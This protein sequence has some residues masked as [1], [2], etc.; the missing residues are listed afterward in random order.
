VQTRSAKNKGVRLQ[1]WV[2]FY[3]RGLG[4]KCR[5]AIM[6]ETGED[7]KFDDATV[8][9]SVE[10]KNQESLNFW[11]AWEQTIGRLKTHQI[12]VLFIKRNRQEPLVVIQADYFFDLI[13][14]K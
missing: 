8:L 2:A 7:I 5:P 13:G 14:K 1:N 10:T 11:K 4:F 3:F 9:W 12:P 6:G